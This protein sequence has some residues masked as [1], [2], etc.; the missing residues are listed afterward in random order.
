[1]RPPF[2]LHFTLRSLFLCPRLL[3]QPYEV[4]KEVPMPFERI[5]TKEILV[6]MERVQQVLEQDEVCA[7]LVL[8]LSALS[9]S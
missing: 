5:V 6:P 2:Q 1:M 8:S 4:I 3:A 9:L 7:I